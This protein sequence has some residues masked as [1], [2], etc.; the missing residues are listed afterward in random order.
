MVLRNQV[1]WALHCALLLS[2]LPPET[3]LSAQALAEFHDV[4]KEYLSKALQALSGAGLVT[5]SL[6]PTGGYRLA[7]PAQD[8]SLLEIVE[9]VEGKRNTFQCSEIRKKGPCAGKAR[10]YSPVC[11]IAQ[12]MYQADEAWR[13]SLRK[14]TVADISAQVSRKILPEF[15]KKFVPWLQSRVRPQ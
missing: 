13:E 4:P 8:I 10:S 2:A 1:E 12:A 5:T 7:R 3:C 11:S 15:E 14:K 6:G 9:A